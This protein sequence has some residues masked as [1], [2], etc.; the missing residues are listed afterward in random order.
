MQ[1][2]RLDAEYE[3][4]QK[5]EKSFKKAKEAAVDVDTQYGIRR[6]VRAMSEDVTR[7]FPAWKRAFQEF[8]ATPLGK[9]SII[10]GVLAIMTTSIF[11]KV[12]G[13]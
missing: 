3:I 9:F 4:S 5:A 1:A 8:S 12:R 10:S 2:T 11:W 13:R 7:H 6:R